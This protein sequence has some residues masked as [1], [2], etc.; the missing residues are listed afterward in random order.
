MGGV[1]LSQLRLQP[2]NEGSASETWCP[3]HWT[4]RELPLFFGEIKC[5]SSLFLFTVKS[6]SLA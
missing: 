4:T 2:S 6:R 3:N 1:F 5:Q